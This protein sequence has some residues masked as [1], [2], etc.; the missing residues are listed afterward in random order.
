M[1]ADAL[2]KRWDAG[3]EDHALAMKCTAGM[4]STLKEWLA[5]LKESWL[6]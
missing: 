6:I 1:L 2:V 4:I 5:F 3:G